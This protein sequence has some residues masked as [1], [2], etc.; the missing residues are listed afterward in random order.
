MDDVQLL[1]EYAIRNS[2]AAFEHLV[3]RHINLVY[4][5]A[6]RQVRDPQLAQE[7]TQVAFIL[8]ARKARSIRE[9]TVLSGWLFKTA[10]FAARR[11]LRSELRRQ[12]YE[13]AGAQQASTNDEAENESTWAQMAPLLD[14]AI[15]SLREQDRQAVLLRFFENKSL[16]EV[17]EA[18][19]NT[20]EAAKKRVARALEKLRAFFY[21]RGVI[22]PAATIAAALAGNSV[23]AAPRGLAASVA[24]IAAVKG[25]TAAVSTLTLVKGTMKMMFWSKVKFAVPVGAALILGLTLPQL[26]SQQQPGTLDPTFKPIVN[27][28]VRFLLGQPDGK[29]LVVASFSDFVANG[30]AVEPRIGIIR[31]NGDGSR[32]PTFTQLK[33]YQADVMGLQPD[34]KIVVG[35]SLI[36]TNTIRRANVFRLNSDGTM[37]TTFNAGIGTELD[38][39]FPQAISLRFDSV[40]VQEDGKIMATGNFSEFA[41][42]KQAGLVRLNRDGSLDSTFKPP[43]RSGDTAGA[44]L[45]QKDGRFVTGVWFINSV[46]P[47]PLLR[48]WTLGMRRFNPDGS[49]DTTFSSPFSNVLTLRAIHTDGKLL[50]TDVHGSSVIGGSTNS[51]VRLN[52][53]GSRD[54]SFVARVSKVQ[55]PNGPNIVVVQRI[56]VQKNGKIII[57]GD[58]NRANGV[59]RSGIARFNPDGSLDQKFDPGSGL[60]PLGGFPI[61][62]LIVQPDGKIV[63]AGGFQTVNGVARPTLVRLLGDPPLGFSSVSVNQGRLEAKVLSELEAP[64]AIESSSD[65]LNW[66]PFGVLTNGPAAISFSD[67]A[68]EVKQRFYRAAAR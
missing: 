34:G 60:S 28:L 20:E 8:L 62:G 24:S 48:S 51:L 2:E 35:G 53:D 29:I 23:Q 32:D 26:W 55:S 56:V 22:V 61:N 49:Y 31:L 46:A 1:R 16:K 17:G 47:P 15:S 4:S 50:G 18:L 27:Y 30:L 42:V 52:A 6:L 66:T 37:D 12:H 68:M 58:F 45:F 11:A 3:V 5:T 33:T 43:T 65:L 54:T 14:E 57:A 59:E 38:N 10:R 21:R 40:A 44:P 39:L 67:S 19:G 25:A 41:G 36:Q 63:I 9:G 64:I 7:A 13:H